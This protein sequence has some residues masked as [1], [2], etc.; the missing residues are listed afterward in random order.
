MF[1]LNDFD[2]I[3]AGPF[4]Y[5]VKRMAASFT[6]AAHNNGFSK[7]DTRASVAVEKAHTRDSSQAL[8]KPGELLDGRYR[9]VCAPHARQRD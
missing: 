1:D 6:I 2:E 8:S 5:E 3:L 4:E 7:A 9:I